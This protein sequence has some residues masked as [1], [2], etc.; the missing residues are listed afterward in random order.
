[1][2]QMERERDLEETKADSSRKQ[3]EKFQ[4]LAICISNAIYKEC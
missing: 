2:Y 1:M 3:E 4:D